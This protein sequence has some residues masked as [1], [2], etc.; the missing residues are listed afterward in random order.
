MGLKC[1]PCIEHFFVM[2]HAP[3]AVCL[4]LSLAEKKTPKS[5]FHQ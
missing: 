1:G 3:S 2:V 5:V 4:D